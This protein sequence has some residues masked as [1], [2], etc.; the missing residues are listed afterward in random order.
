MIVRLFFRSEDHHH[1]A[2]FHPR[3]LLNDPDFRQIGFNAGEQFLPETLVRHFAPA[4]ADGYF[5]F[6]TI[7]KETVQVA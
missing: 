6:V 4:E 3:F 2:A 5:G 1:L 7:S